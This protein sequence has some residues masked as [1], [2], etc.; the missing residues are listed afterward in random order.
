M[1]DTS[2]YVA[3][4]KGHPYATGAF[5]HADSLS[6]NPV[7]MGELRFGF[8]KSRWK[9]EN[10]SELNRFLNSPRVR[11]IDVDAGTA[12]RYAAI[13]AA[14]R[15]AG[16]PIPINDV[17]IASTAMQHGLTLLTSDGHY[18]SVTQIIVERFDP[19]SG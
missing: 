2:A 3:F 12:E 9:K 16:T 7:V 8:W 17:W 14:L 15:Q 19:I 18:R 1:L 10:E 6:L 5:L 11:V 4:T 13:R